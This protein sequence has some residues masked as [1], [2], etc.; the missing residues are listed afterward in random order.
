MLKYQDFIDNLTIEQKLSLLADF[1]SLGGADSGALDVHFLSETS[2]EEMNKNTLNGEIFP[3]FAGLVNSWDGSLVS[4]VADVLSSRARKNGYALLNIPQANVKT[5]PYSDGYTEDPVLSAGMISSYVSAGN[6]WGV[7]TC[8]S[9]P[10]MSETDALYSD[11]ERNERA[12]Y[13]YFFKPFKLLLK[14]GV[15]AVRTAQ[16]TLNGSYEGVNDELLKQVEEKTSVV[17]EC[18]KPSDVLDFVRAGNRLCKK[19]DA[20]TLKAAL[21]KYAALQ[22]QF[23][24]GEI[25]INDVETECRNGYA[26]SPAKIDES[27]D[28][29]LDFIQT[30]TNMRVRTSSNDNPDEESLA[31]KAVEESVVLLKNENKTLPLKGKTV[32]LV[33]HLAERTQGAKIE[34]LKNQMSAIAQKGGLRYL[35]YAK[36]Y[37]F[38]QDRSDKLLQ[39]AC[40]LVKGADVVVVVMGFDGQESW[41]A[42][43][44]KNSRLPGNQLALMEALSRLNKK[45]VAIVGGECYPDMKFDKA[46]SAVLLAPLESSGSAQAIGNVL[47]GKANPSGKLAFTCYNNTDEHFRQLRTYKEAGR[48]KVGTFYGYRH[49]DTSGLRVKYPFGHGLSY[50]QFEYADLL[51]TASGITFTVKN[52]GHT[53]GAEVVQLYVGKSDSAVIRPKKELKAFEK[54]FLS[55][56]ETKRLTFSPKQLDLT[57]W[58][59]KKGKAVTEQG[60]YDVYVGSSSKDIRLTESFLYGSDRLEKDKEKLSDYLQAKS[61]ILEE[62]YHLENPVQLPEDVRGKRRRFAVVA[63]IVL[64]CLDIV[65]GYFNFVRWAPREWWVYLIVGVVN[66]LPIG[67]AI[68][69]TAKRKKEIKDCL[70][71]NMNEK[72]RKREELNID[73]LAEELP[74]EELFEAEFSLAPEM[75]REEIVEAKEKAE[76]KTVKTVPFDE[77]FTLP[78][79]CEE[80]VTFLFERGVAIDLSTARSILAAFASSRLLILKSDEN[81]LLFGLIPLL[82]EYFKSSIALDRYNESYLDGD[83]LLHYKDAWGNVTRTEIARKLMNATLEDNYLHIAAL[84]GMQCAAIKSTFAPVIR[85]VDQPERETQI[86]VKGAQT[87]TYD[88]AQNVWFIVTLGEGEKITD[89]PKYILDMACVVDVPLRAAEARTRLV[90]ENLPAAQENTDEGTMTETPVETVEQELAETP[91]NEPIASNEVKI[92]ETV[93]EREKTPVKTLVYSQFEKLT[94]RAFRDY[95]IDEILWKRVDKIEE[96]VGACTDYRIENKLWQRMEKYASAYLA[97]G[98]EEEE[99]L[100]CVMARHLIPAMLVCLADAKKLPEEKFAHA[101]E[102]IFGEGHV[103]RSLKVIKSTDLNV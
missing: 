92:V 50:T 21:E 95:Q 34:S 24:A 1:S 2:V 81:Q 43:R 48:N 32:A 12:V 17:Y 56:G 87:E 73:E 7:K 91:E 80:L 75:E 22:E 35:G 55:P 100:D 39:E 74:Y 82:C 63:S 41:K 60:F 59:V 61:N 98:G 88:V 90:V 6:A 36:G 40:E 18:K 28:Y 65:Y 3:T 51:C 71:E 64:L 86:V 37:D 77:E 52:T 57:V 4:K 10:T 25:S 70:V 15:G 9:D 102:N 54:V 97:A 67:F 49:Y 33:G 26:I 46:C 19:G 85:Y 76:K 45:I 38:T 42:K 5:T 78:T 101:M 62:K 13:E 79:V 94:H 20:A 68:A 58:N 89:I 16:P 69:L 31:I 8:I 99:A 29:V 23:E 83:G 93:I 14:N 11:K 66:A 53:A 72:Q 44:N 47:V 84:S 30:C 96:Y 103:N 27:L